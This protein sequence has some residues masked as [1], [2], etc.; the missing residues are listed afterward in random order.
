MRKAII[1]SRVSTDEQSNERQIS[2][3]TAKASHYGMTI[4]TNFS[5][6]ISG[7]KGFF[8]R[9]GG[10]ALMNYI[11]ENEVTDIVV[12]EISRISRNVEDTKK[13]IR[14]LSGM[15]VNL[16][17]SNISMDTLDANGNTNPLVALVTSVLGG[18]AEYERELLRERTRS[19]MRHAKAQ[20]KQI[21]R[22]RTEVSIEAE[23]LL[24]MGESAK[25]VMKITGMSKSQVYRLRSK[26]S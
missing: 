21:G 19:G 17:I 4:L 16:H 9:D 25:N 23:K 15:G 7:S 18:V 22:E 20:G 6:K 26:I 5:D 12:S 3:L 10:N 13:V 1:Y 14:I 2:E 8:D 11:K 24:K